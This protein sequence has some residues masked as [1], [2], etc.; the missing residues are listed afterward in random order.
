MTAI[1]QAGAISHNEIDWHAL[2]WQKINQNVRRLQ[3]RIVKAMKEGRR[4]KVKSLQRLLTHSFSSKALAI[5]RVTENHGKKT[6]GVDGEI[7][8][9]P[10]KKATAIGT[11]NQRGYQPLPLRRIFIPKRNGKKR[12]LSIPAMKDRAMQALHLLALDPIAETISDPNSYGF[13]KERATADAIEQCHQVLN[14]Y[15]GA[16]EWILEGDIRSCF[17]KISHQW[18]MDNILMDKTI[19]HKWLKAGFVDRHAFYKTEE[20]TPQGSIISPVLARLT[21]TGLEHQLREKYPKAVRKIRSAKVNMIAFAD[22][23]II[24]G[25]S[26]ELL[27]NEVKPLVEDFLKERGLELSEEKTKITHIEDGFDFLGQNVRKYKGKI[28]IK[29][30]K[31]NIKN[32]LGKVRAI[33]RGN[34]QAK[35]ENLINQLNPVIRGWVNYHRYVVSKQTFKK[36]DHAIFLALWQW[37]KRRHPHK[38]KRW[39][40]DKYFQV[41]NGRKWR[42]CAETVGKNGK[43][44]KVE[45]FQAASTPIKRHRKIKGE[46][47]PYDRQWEIYFEERLGLKMLDDLKERR[48]LLNLWFGQ[49]GSCVVCSERITKETGWNIHHLVRRTDGGKETM[50]NLVLL[51]PNCHRQVHSQ[52]MEVSKPRSMKRASRKAQAV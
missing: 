18:M 48:K 22:D 6:P 30:S 49:E 2:D 37:A 23:F 10:E 3:A 31:K 51:D 8:N 24:T 36:A 9:T 35:T 52:G 19:L 47:N 29:P 26:K 17:D 21:L 33:I 27:E 4:G 25:K 42:F 1:V 34:K 45:L 12:P 32:F 16:A 14:R 41:I 40:K 43:P 7:W 11:L 15:N 50:E 44:L 5:K 39:I 13:R 46:A 28:L 38:P 20:G